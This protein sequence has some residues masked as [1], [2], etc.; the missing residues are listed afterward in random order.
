MF[1]LASEPN[2]S[3]TD[4]GVPGADVSTSIMGRILGDLRC[5]YKS[6]SCIKHHNAYFS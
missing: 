4:L 2:G 5:H 3:G 6:G 1:P